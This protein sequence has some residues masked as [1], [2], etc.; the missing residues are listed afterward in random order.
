[1][2]KKVL[3]EGECMFEVREDD[4]FLVF[5]DQDLLDYL[6]EDDELSRN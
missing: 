3:A 4:D 5:F 6:L 1:M 2:V